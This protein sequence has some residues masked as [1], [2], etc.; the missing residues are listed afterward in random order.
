MI[1]DV[2]DSNYI[3][4]GN[5]SKYSYAQYVDALNGSGSFTIRAPLDS[6][7]LSYLTYGVYILFESKIMGEIL[8]INVAHN[9]EQGKRE[10]DITE[11]P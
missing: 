6:L 1:L 8:Q 9:E 4:V 11:K 2:F 3:R 5:I 10:I 7:S